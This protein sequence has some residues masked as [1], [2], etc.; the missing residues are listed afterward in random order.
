MSES[1][2]VKPEEEQAHIAIVL[3]VCFYL[4]FR[5]RGTKAEDLGISE[6]DIRKF[7]YL[8]WP[9]RNLSHFKLGRELS[10][11]VTQAIY[12]QHEWLAHTSVETHTL[13][14]EPLFVWIA[15]QAGRNGG[16]WVEIKPVE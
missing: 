2:L 7:L 13:R 5:A 12:P 16:E 6:D 15:R 10:L 3:F 11:E 8:V 1:K 4:A 14:E 9:R